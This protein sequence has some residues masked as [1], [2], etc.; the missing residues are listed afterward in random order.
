[1]TEFIK[2][3]GIDW[4]MLLSQITA[5]FVLLAFLKILAYKPILAML[6]KRQEKIEKGLAQAEEAKTRLFEID[7]ISV[8]K[9]KEDDQKE[10]EIIKAK[11][12][13]KTATIQRFT[14]EVKRG[15]LKDS[16]FDLSN[17][18][19]DFFCFFDFSGLATFFNLT[20]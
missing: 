5:F 15:Y 10:M 8:G 1:M 12:N 20:T 14:L 16:L 2:Q 17:F 13:I 4:K 19:R 11:T 9:L 18:C 6:K 3:F 7:K